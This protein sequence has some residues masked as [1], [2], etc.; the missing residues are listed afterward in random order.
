MS[1]DLAEY[2]VCMNEFNTSDVYFGGGSEDCLYLDVYTSCPNSNKKLPVRNMG[3]RET[4]A[5][6]STHT[7]VRG[8][9]NTANSEESGHLQ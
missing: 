2:F 5:V 3:K 4:E 7:S 8:I 6:G 1:N 9:P